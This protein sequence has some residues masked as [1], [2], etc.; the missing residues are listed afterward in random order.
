MRLSYKNV[1]LA[2]V[3]YKPEGGPFRGHY[4]RTSAS[5]LVK[6]NLFRI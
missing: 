4:F 5:S 3:T 1:V 6:P 2:F